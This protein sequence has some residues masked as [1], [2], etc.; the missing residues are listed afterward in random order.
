MK[1]LVMSVCVCGGGGPYPQV[2]KNLDNWMQLKILI[3]DE[4]GHKFGE[5]KWVAQT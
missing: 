2:D 1:R 5:E 4:P 3:T